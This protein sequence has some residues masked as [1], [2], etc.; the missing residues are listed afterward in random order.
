M[1]SQ[2]L[3]VIGGG[4]MARS[5]VQGALRV[6]VMPPSSWRVVEPDDA[7]RA[8]FEAFLVQSFASVGE[9][10]GVL[11]PDE[12]VLLAIKPQSLPEVAQELAAVG[13][14][15]RVVITILAGTPSETVRK[16]LGGRVRVVRAMPNLAAQI[17][18]GA[19]A[20]ALGAGAKPG[21][22]DLAYRIFAAAGPVVEPLGEG[23]MDAFTAVAGSGPAY[24]FFLAEAMVK[25]AVETGIDAP[26]AERIVVQTLK[27]AVALINS[28]RSSP[29]ELR[30]TVT[31]KG[32]TTEAALGVLEREG[33]QGALVRA[34]VAARDRGAELAARSAN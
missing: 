10:K 28:T 1:S 21:D 20:V 26:T 29:A 11:E 16:A 30:Q 19:T 12:Q 9:L 2:R 8:E 6:H 31:S 22:D 14:G 15:E 18:E 27:G 25:A 13:M 32:G 24:L 5:I 33:V 4:N 23:L 34:L 17:G 3:T 7:R